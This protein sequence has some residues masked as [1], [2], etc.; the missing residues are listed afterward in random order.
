MLFGIVVWMRMSKGK[1]V[2]GERGDFMFSGCHRN[3]CP[4][5]ASRLGADECHGTGDC[6]NIV[7]S[8]AAATGCCC[9]TLG[10][11]FLPRGAQKIWT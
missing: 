11:L 8:I 5:T 3:G 10:I 1:S 4:V 6:L 9:N 2:E 7:S